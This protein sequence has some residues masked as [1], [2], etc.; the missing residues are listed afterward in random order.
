MTA[1]ETTEADRALVELNVKIAEWEQRR[2]K[3]AVKRLDES[4]S[5]EL[6]FRRA[7]RTVVSKKAFMDALGKPGPFTKRESRDVS[8]TIS[9][10]RALVTLIVVATK[11]DGSLG[12]Y[13]NIRVFFRREGAWQLEVWFNDD[14][15]SLL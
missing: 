14:L 7:D 3:D 1:E 11:I 4:L 8:L 12:R 10:E 9:G 13:R 5:S 6:V 15:T 2:D